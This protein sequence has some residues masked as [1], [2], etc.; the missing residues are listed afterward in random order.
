MFSSTVP[1]LLTLQPHKRQDAPVKT[2]RD[3]SE[4]Q[5]LHFYLQQYSSNW[6]GE[7]HPAQWILLL[8]IVTFAVG[9]VNLETKQSAAPPPITFTQPLICPQNRKSALYRSVIELEADW[10]P[11]RS[12]D[13]CFIL[14]RKSLQPWNDWLN[15]CNKKKRSPYSTCTS[16]LQKH[17]GSVLLQKCFQKGELMQLDSVTPDGVC[18]SGRC[19]AGGKNQRVPHHTPKCEDKVCQ[20]IF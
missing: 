18:S 4:L 19:S 7:H 8:N 16:K 14:W 15:S 11:V 10:I 2:E 12:A 5:Y 20:S 1:H 13:L 9:G 17:D 3:R 6:E